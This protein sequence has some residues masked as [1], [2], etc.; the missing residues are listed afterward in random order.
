MFKRFLLILSFGLFGLAIQA[1][2][3][4]KGNV[5]LKVGGAL[6][7][8]D[9]DESFVLGFSFSGEGIVSDD[10]GN[11]S[12]GLGISLG[13]LSKRFNSVEGGFRTIGTVRNQ[14]AALKGVWYPKA[15]GGEVVQAY[16]SL[17]FGLRHN[18]RVG[19]FNGV[20]EDLKAWEIGHGYSVGIQLAPNEQIGAYLDLGFGLSNINVGLYYVIGGSYNAMSSTSSK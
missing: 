3:L 19:T 13:T 9:I 1:Q 18:F 11:G 6:G 17:K 16:L 5:L 15:L 20:D 14:F 2:S 10:F 8:V 7:T 4:T 12:M